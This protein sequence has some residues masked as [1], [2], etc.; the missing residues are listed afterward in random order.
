MYALHYKIINSL[1]LEHAYSLI[2]YTLTTV[3]YSIAVAI[4]SERDITTKQQLLDILHGTPK[5]EEQLQQEVD[6]KNLCTL[7]KL[8]KAVGEQI[9]IVEK[10]HEDQQPEVAHR[11]AVG[12][13]DI[14][15]HKEMRW[16]ERMIDE[17]RK[18]HD[19]LYSTYTQME[20]K[21]NFKKERKKCL[22]EKLGPKDAALVMN[23][24]EGNQQ[25]SE[26]DQQRKELQKKLS[27]T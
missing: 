26:R 2:Q 1:I 14:D 19:H 20:K 17:K 12:M 4:M 16:V 5:S 25:E 8:H 11:I 15:L 21:E 3:T 6:T 7:E 10:A 24:M 13:L 22:V 18:Q 27:L 9:A 23:A